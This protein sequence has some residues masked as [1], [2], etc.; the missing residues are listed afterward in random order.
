MH[1]QRS[2]RKDVVRRKRKTPHRLPQAPALGVWQC[3][4]ARPPALFFFII[5][6][7]SPLAS[8]LPLARESDQHSNL[9]CRCLRSGG[10]KRMG[11]AGRGDTLCSTLW[12]TLREAAGPCERRGAHVC[13]VLGR[14]KRVLCC[15]KVRKR[16]GA[17]Y[18]RAE[19]TASNRGG[20]QPRPCKETETHDAL[21]SAQRET[22]RPARCAQLSTL[23]SHCSAA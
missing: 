19:V 4:R 18:A 20:R 8:S 22:A 16:P 1:R 12:H 13:C 21:G 15:R 7:G 9:S 5:P 2:A 17:A 6:L 3:V 23:S 11:K 10:G 14:R